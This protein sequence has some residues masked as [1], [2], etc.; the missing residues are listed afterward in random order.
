MQSPKPWHLIAPDWA[1][2]DTVWRS[3]LPFAMWPVCEKPLLAHWLDEAVRRGVPSVTIEAVDRP[4]ILRAWLDQRD[5]WSRSIRIFSR[6]SAPEDAEVLRIEAL[7]G[8]EKT[9]PVESPAALLE[10]FYLLQNEAIARRSKDMVHLDHELEPGIWTGPRASVAPG[11]QFTPPCWIGSHAK[12][13]P[14]CKIGPRAFIG[15]GVFVD[16]DVEIAESVVCA[17]T[18]VG[19]HT[20][21]KNNIA[22]GGLL[23]DL[24][25]GIS[26]D[27]TDSFVLSSLQSNSSTPGIFE[28]L[29]AM[30]LFPFLE[31]AARILSRGKPPEVRRCEIS[32]GVTISLST[33]AAGPLALRRANWLRAVAS[34]K[35]RWIGILPRTNEEWAEIPP[36]LRPALEKAPTGVFSLADL[37]GCHSPDQPDEWLH[38]AFQAGTENHVGH[39]MV[40]RNFFKIFLTVPVT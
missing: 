24:A 26:I 36:D 19:S 17:E 27:I 34:G 15:P 33:H 25:R 12:I 28:R 18:Y 13:G 5:M 29:S 37:Y 8:M 4:Q 40:R 20:T 6:P 35:M 38:A 31:F 7:P 2:L 10:R 23:I 9:P 32:R 3:P 22:Q 21:L 14:G 30:L 11:T 1:A 16:E 39:R